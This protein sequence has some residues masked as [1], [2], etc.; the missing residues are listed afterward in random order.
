MLSTNTVVCLDTFIYIYLRL[1]EIISDSSTALF[2]AVNLAQNVE[3][4]TAVWRFDDHVVGDDPNT[5]NN[6]VIYLPMNLPCP[7]LASKN[8]WMSKSLSRGSLN[9]SSI[10]SLKYSF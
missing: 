2:S 5:E 8:K 10:S 4:C 3:V 6:P 9:C 1:Y 7:W